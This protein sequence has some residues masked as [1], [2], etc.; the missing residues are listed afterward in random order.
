MLGNEDP[1]ALP[2]VELDLSQLPEGT[3]RIAG[4]EVKWEE[5]TEVYRDTK[6]FF[7]DDLDEETPSELKETAMS[8]YQAL[9]LRDYG[10]I[11]IRLRRRAAST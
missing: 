1:E 8:A 3:P 10:R 11:D 5:G 7:P 9:Q 2:I 6:P 4:T